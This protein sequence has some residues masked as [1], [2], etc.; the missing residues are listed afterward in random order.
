MFFFPGKTGLFTSTVKQPSSQFCPLFFFLSKL[1]SRGRCPR[2]GAALMPRQVEEMPRARRP[3]NT[4]PY[5]RAAGDELDCA[6]VAGV[7]AKVAARLAAK[8]ARAFEEADR[9]REELIAQNVGLDDKR[10]EWFMCD[11]H[12]GR[13]MMPPPR[14]SAADD[15]RDCARK[16]TTSAKGHGALLRGI[17]FAQHEQVCMCHSGATMLV[18]TPEP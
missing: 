9:I 4:Q 3:P 5:A 14:V 1:S 12:T 7:E 13:P 8:L 18:R 16:S 17:G 6:D 2:T 10:R 11:A 15:V